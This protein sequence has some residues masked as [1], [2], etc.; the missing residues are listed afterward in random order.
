[1][2]KKTVLGDSR[3][4]VDPMLL[5]AIANREKDRS[6]FLESAFSNVKPAV[7]S[8]TSVSPK[9]RIVKKSSPSPSQPL[10]SNIYPEAIRYNLENAVDNTGIVKESMLHNVR[11]DVKP[12]ISDS[13]LWAE[14]F[15]VKAG[16]KKLD[17]G[18]PKID[19]SSASS[20][21]VENRPMRIPSVMRNDGTTPLDKMSFSS[22]GM[23]SGMKYDANPNADLRDSYGGKSG[24]AKHLHDMERLGSRKEDIKNVTS[25]LGSEMSSKIIDSQREAIDP[26]ND[27][28]ISQT[29][30]PSNNKELVE[31]GAA[32]LHV[33]RPL[34]GSYILVRDGN[35]EDRS[36]IGLHEQG[37]S[38]HFSN[39][40][41]VGSPNEWASRPEEIGAVVSSVKQRELRNNKDLFKNPLKLDSDIDNIIDN[42]KPDDADNFVKIK[43]AIYK[44]HGAE[45]GKSVLR[46]LFKVIAKNKSEENKD[47][48]A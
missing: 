5:E 17:D 47:N 14:R 2:S 41:P 35:K 10:V 3:T 36:V 20:L 44:K 16:N 39:G 21:A 22:N 4:K 7:R 48:L 27:F 37:H 12:N 30:V 24:L 46:S 38:R 43:Q 31:E 40:K 9:A 28:T 29:I 23:F 1:M 18:L 33:S 6:K 8:S 13:E 11:F 15:V 42:A 26:S 34:S 25:V 45:K 19:A 32:G